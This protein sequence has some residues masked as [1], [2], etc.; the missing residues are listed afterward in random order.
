MRCDNIY[1]AAYASLRELYIMCIII[2]PLH[3]KYDRSK[4]VSLLIHSPYSPR[5]LLILPGHKIPIANATLSQNMPFVFFLSYRYSLNL[6]DVF[7][8]S[9]F[10]RSRYLSKRDFKH[11]S[12]KSSF[13]FFNLFKSNDVT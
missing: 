11:K 6:C 12:Q 5:V 7:F 4:R 8:F 10:Q 13:F 9:P 2:Y 3:C 1:I